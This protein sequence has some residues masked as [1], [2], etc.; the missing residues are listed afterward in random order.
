VIIGAARLKEPTR[1][2]KA[3]RRPVLVIALLEAKIGLYPKNLIEHAALSR[4]RPKAAESGMC[5][6]T[7]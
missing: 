4:S 6:V 7:L 1:R 5:F 2:N 3:C